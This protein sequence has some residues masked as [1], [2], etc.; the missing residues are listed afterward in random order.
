MVQLQAFHQGCLQP[1]KCHEVLRTP[2]H[3]GLAA[4]FRFLLRELQLLL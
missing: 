3:L 1:L 2:V 4:R